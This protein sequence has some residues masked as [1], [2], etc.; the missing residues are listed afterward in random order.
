MF[1]NKQFQLKDISIVLI[2]DFYFW[3]LINLC[4]IGLLFIIINTRQHTYSLDIIKCSF[5]FQ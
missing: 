2:S 1:K 5:A 4:F 3:Y